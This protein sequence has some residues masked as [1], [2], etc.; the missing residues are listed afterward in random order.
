[1]LHNCGNSKQERE[2]WVKTCRVYA[3]DN[4]ITSPFL[5]ALVVRTVSSWVIGSSEWFVLGTQ[6]WHIKYACGNSA[7]ADVP[8]RPP[9]SK[10]LTSKIPQTVWISSSLNSNSFH[11]FL[12]RLTIIS[13][14]RVHRAG[15]FLPFYKVKD[16]KDAFVSKSFVGNLK[17]YFGGKFHI[18]RHV[19]LTKIIT[20]TK[21]N[22]QRI[23]FVI[24]VVT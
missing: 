9:T 18:S 4:E 24:L 15:I 6:S 21:L 16:G 14:F 12:M 10:Q 17:I 1:M 3:Y 11:W 8:F 7:L 13:W 20:Q 23:L 19:N 22:S 2:K 5:S